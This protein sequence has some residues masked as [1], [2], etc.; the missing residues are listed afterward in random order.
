MLIMVN[1]SSSGGYKVMYWARPA[2]SV[3]WSLMSGEIVLSTRIAV[4]AL[5]PWER[6]IGIPSF[7]YDS[8]YQNSTPL[9]GSW[10]STFPRWCSC[11]RMI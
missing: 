2:T 3:P 6:P 10:A 4:P 1:D 9:A 11:S 8:P 5:I 7:Q